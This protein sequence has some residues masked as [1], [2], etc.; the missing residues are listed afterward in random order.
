MRFFLF[1]VLEA[2][3]KSMFLDN[4]DRESVNGILHVIGN[5]IDWGSE[6]TMMKRIKFIRLS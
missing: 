4:H 6:D 1:L 3:G 2:S 5:H